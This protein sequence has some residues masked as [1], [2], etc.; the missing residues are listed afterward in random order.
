MPTPRK[1]YTAMSIKARARGFKTGGAKRI[2]L[3]ETRTKTHMK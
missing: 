2:R 3:V 1:R